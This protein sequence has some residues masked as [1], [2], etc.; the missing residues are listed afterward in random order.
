MFDN[1]KTE[2]PDIFDKDENEIS[3]RLPEG[4][5]TDMLVELCASNIQLPNKQFE[6]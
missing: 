6:Q 3:E 5:I 4:R 1:T 2:I